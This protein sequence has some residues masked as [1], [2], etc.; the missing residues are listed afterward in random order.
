MG[1]AKGFASHMTYFNGLLGGRQG[2]SGPNRDSRH[3]H[4]PF[5]TR[6][7]RGKRYAAVDKYCRA[8]TV[9]RWD[10]MNA[11]EADVGLKALTAEDLRRSGRGE[12]AATDRRK[13]EGA[14]GGGCLLV[15][16]ICDPA[17]PR[18]LPAVDG[19]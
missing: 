9:P 12:A 18:L 19:Y 17:V 10:A 16:I 4:P 3:G 2:G 14:V 15:G 8:T 13:Q 5:R 11:I 1:S 7:A 6:Y